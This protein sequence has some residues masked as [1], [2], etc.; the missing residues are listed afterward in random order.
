MAVQINHEGTAWKVGNN[1]ASP[2]LQVNTTGIGFH[3]TT[4]C[5]QCAAYTQTFSTAERTHAA[6]TAGALTDNTTGT[7]GTTFAAGAGCMTIS[8]PIVLATIPNGDVLTNY[9]PGYAFKIL[10]VTAA[11]TTAA[12]TADKLATLNLEIGSTNVTG[13]EVALTTASC[14]TLGKLTAGA[15]ITAANTGTA[16]D[17]ISIEGS[18]V[19]AFVEGSIVL[20]IKIQNM[21]TANAI[22]SLIAEHAKLVADLA[23]TGGVV[24]AIVDDLQETG[25][26]A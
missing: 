25:I 26:C 10:S 7:A 17:T 24:N 22:A 20:L 6:R 8:I 11:V 4:P 3:G 15:A 18:S 19:T 12:S 13:G 2:T 5:D 21:D 1:I 16:T 23:D 14:N 9:T